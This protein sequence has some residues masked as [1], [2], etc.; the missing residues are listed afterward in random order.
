M[1][2]SPAATLIACDAVAAARLHLVLLLR[3]A[4]S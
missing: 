2:R 4:R 1:V 3:P